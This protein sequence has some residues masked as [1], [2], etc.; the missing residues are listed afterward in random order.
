MPQNWKTYKLGEVA[1]L[2]TGFAFKS[3]NYENE[4]DL[5]VIRGKNVT[6]GY[7]RW[8]NDARYWNHSL[9]KLDKYNVIEDDIVIG[10]DGS[11]IGKNRA[12]V[13]KHDLPVILAQRVAKVR[14]IQGKASQKYI[15]QLINNKPFENY[16]ENVKT[17][18]S[19]PHISLGQIKDFEIILPPLEDQV[20]I[21]SILTALDDKIELN[22]Q[23]NKT[24]E[25]M[26]MALY[27]HWFV[28]QEDL[29]VDLMPLS[30]V[31]EF[32][33]DNRGRTAPTSEE[34]IPLIATNCVKN[35]NIF[36]TYERVRYIDDETYNN[37]FRA[38]PISGDILFVNKGAP[39]S[40]NLVPI[41]VDFCIAQDMVALRANDKICS[42]YYLFIYLRQTSTQIEILNK[43]VGTTIPHLKKTDLLN[44]EIPIPEKALIDKYTNKVSP[45]F[46][47][48]DILR[49]ENQTL[50]KLRDTLLPKLISGEV[51]VKE[52]LKQV[53]ELL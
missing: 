15:W 25:E 32:I 28:E 53:K 9:D 52:A 47:K 26:A 29:E 49:K 6:E 10:M 12:V 3:K 35:K 38:H 14:A 19:I 23:M 45:L 39:G 50:T 13:R 34:G 27:K 31:V 16:V 51:R 30:E 2:S 21:A 48:L 17:G 5:R 46:E 22:L 24:L 41:P 18:T 20:A 44:F 40:V 1:E 7:L 11:K 43:S 36:P 4:G 42:N 8:G 37:W 33:V